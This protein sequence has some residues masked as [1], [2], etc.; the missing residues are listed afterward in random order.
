MCKL[1]TEVLGNEAVMN[2]MHDM[3][4]NQQFGAYEASR[5]GDLARALVNNSVAT[6]LIFFVEEAKQLSPHRSWTSAWDHCIFYATHPLNHCVGGNFIEQGILAELEP[7]IGNGGELEVE[8]AERLIKCGWTEDHGWSFRRA[9]LE[10][11]RQCL[12]SL[13]PLVQP[14][15]HE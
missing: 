14:L 8:Y 10:E 4:Y 13:T 5:D 15:L 3:I 11:L 9:F 2:A 7:I 6:A 12:G 1:S